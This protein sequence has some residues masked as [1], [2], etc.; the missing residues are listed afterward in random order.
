MRLAREQRIFA[1]HLSSTLLSHGHEPLERPLGTRVLDAV[2]GEDVV[3]LF[4]LKGQHIEGPSTRLRV[5]NLEHACITVRIVLWKIRA[6][7]A[8]TI[9]AADLQQIA[10]N[11]WN[12]PHRALTL[13]V[14]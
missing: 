1:G 14:C 2:D 4:R 8:G 7:D 9:N 3:L 10:G 5:L 6:G 13:S 12:S 11:G